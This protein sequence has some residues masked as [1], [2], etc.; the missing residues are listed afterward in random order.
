MNL[1]SHFKRKRKMLNRFIYFLAKRFLTIRDLDNILLYHSLANQKKLLL[2]K[3]QS[4][5][6]MQIFLKQQGLAFQRELEEQDFIAFELGVCSNIT[7]P[8]LAQLRTF[9]I[10]NERRNKN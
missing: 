5:K 8:T 10:K 7:Y 3:Q 6:E 2:I 9:K 1:C 4:E